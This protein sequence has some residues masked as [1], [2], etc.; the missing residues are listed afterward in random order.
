MKRVVVVGAG[1]AGLAAADALRAGGAEVTVL[2]AR[3]RVGGRVWSVPFGEG[4]T[5]ERGGEFILPG[6]E[7]MESL[8]ARFGIPLVLKGTPYGR[9]IPVGEEAV[10]QAELEGVF[11]RIGAAPPAAGGSVAE[12]VDALG[13][14]PRLATLIKNRVATSNGHPSEDLEASVLEEGASTFGDFDNF[15]LEG[16]NQR[17]AT[18]LAAEL[19]DA[20]H[21]G[22]PARRVRW[23]EGEV[24]VATDSG[25]VEAE[26]AVIA[27]P[28]APLS[29]VEFEPPLRGATA[30]AL[31][32]VVYGQNSKLFVPLRS[33]APPSAIVS[34]AGHFWSYTQLGADG[35]PAPFLVGYTGT[36]AAIEALGGDAEPERWQAALLALR[37]D[38]DLD[39]DPAAALLSSW[40]DDPWV[41]GS[42][43]AR[44]VSSPIRD[45]DL[46][47]PI[48]PLHFAGEHTAG[49]WHGLMEGALRSGLRAAD[50][51][52]A[53]GS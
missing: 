30:E 35:A 10:A 22:A 43:S 46:T 14:E 18:A 2:E 31:R 41:R 51:V 12:A 40:H 37:S 34:V 27:I 42:Y 4:A 52:L 5:V 7:A 44:T 47:R 6:Y 1:F 24:T 53:T 25:E 17:L 8:A 3:E 26:A 16:G 39:P 33:P 23:G 50:Q 36:A 45:E 9:R 15:T 28:T 11:A 29:E 38:L 48:D 13:L 20:V 19:G 21:L 49:E 32:A